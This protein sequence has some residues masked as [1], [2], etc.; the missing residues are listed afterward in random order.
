MPQPINISASR[1]AAI[2]GLSSWKTPREAWLEI[3]EER[4][5]GFCDKNNYV[6]PEKP[7]NVA[8]RW[9]KAF[10]SA[11]IE[12]AERKTGDK[13]I[14]REKFLE[15]KSCENCKNNPDDVCFFWDTC[16][17]PEKKYI[18]FKAKTPIT[19]HID[20]RYGFN[21]GISAS[22]GKNYLHEG[23]T[24]TEWTF[25]ESYGEP[26]TD[27]IPIEY[28]VQCQHQIICT[29]ANQDILS[30]LVFPKRV[31]EFEE[32]G[33]KITDTLSLYNN[34]IKY[35]QDPLTWAILL[36]EMGYFHQFIIKPDAELQKKMIAHYTD[37]W[38]NNV[39]KK[40]PPEPRNID[41]IKMLVRDPIGTVI[42]TPEITAMI[43]EL[44]DIQKEIGAG[45]SLKKRENQIKTDVMNFIISSEK[46]T[47]DDSRDKF[48]L[49]DN[50]GRKLISYYKDKNGKLILR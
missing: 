24:T 40:I 15:L 33:W 4:E 46:I 42:S 50:D 26:G 9:G 10:E 16:Y 48:I 22:F 3:M 35:F 11:I 1:G 47:D 45:G 49:R 30:V 28:Q 12:I 41:D 34:N 31:E 17:A 25:R 36:N 6:L 21:N 20:G 19:C 39:L 23:K 32:I 38:E 7:D 14:D 29:G 27:Q 2:L 43:N 13:I 44:R 5:P 37:F 18:N 8:I